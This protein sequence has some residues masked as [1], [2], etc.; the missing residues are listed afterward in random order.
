MQLFKRLQRRL[1]IFQI[2]LLLASCCA[3]AYGSLRTFE[4]DLE[5]D[6]MR[7]SDVIARSLAGQ[8][9]RALE[10]GIAFRHF[11]GVEDLF[12][13]VRASNPEI[14]FIAAIDAGATHAFVAGD[15][16]AAQILGSLAPV[17]A[18]EVKSGQAVTPAALRWNQYLVAPRPIMQAEKPLGW[19]LVAVDS[20]YIQDKISEIFYDILVVL[21]V[22]LL[23]TFELLLLIMSTSSTPMLALQAVFAQVGAKDDADQAGTQHWPSP[24]QQLAL[25]MRT[26][27]RRLEARHR[28]LTLPAQAASALTAP[29]DLLRAA[30][31]AIE[32]L[33][34]KHTTMAMMAGQDALVRVRLPLFVFFLAEELS[35]SFFPIFVRGL[36]LSFTGL[37]PEIVVSLPM[38]LFMLVVAFTQPLGGPWVERLGARRLMLG[39]ALLGAVGLAL[40]ATADNLTA[41]LAFRLLTAVGYG[42][43]FVAGQGHVVAQTHPGNRAWGLA[44]FVGSVLAASICGPAIGGILADRI[45]YRWTFAVGSSMAL[46]AAFLAWRLLRTASA[47]PAAQRRPLRL[48][49]VGVVLR[50]PRFLALIG[51]GAMPAK[52]ILTGFL[53]YLAPLYLAHLGN[54]Q[55]ATGRI[56]MLYGLMMVLLT[57]IAA[58]TAD[59]VGRP[60][61]FVVL[62]GLLSG[63]GLLGVLWS[64]STGMVL[65]GIVILGLAQAIS[66]TPQLSLVPVACAEE[67]KAMGQVTVIGFFRLFERIGSALGPLFAAF[68]LRTF[69]YVTAIVAIGGGVGL[70]CILLGL[71][72]HFSPGRRDQAAAAPVL[73]AV[74]ASPQMEKA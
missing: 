69:D 28:S 73:S 51:L 32:A 44:M 41:L 35:R 22:S 67:C 3:V 13:S 66:I 47:S 45:G 34:S 65:F 57:P 58:R 40:T 26:I 20:H 8:F 70:A 37:S 12:S 29:T 16:R 49:D 61:L 53:Y 52:I 19:L 11:R 64:A 59:R 50:N 39:G 24:V 55:S 2:F 74:T 9:E 62:G 43:V 71:T 18:G 4:A 15:A 46:L 25:V 31:T 6:M 17:L 48:R 14:G 72:W 63:A 30:D 68:L 38:M 27:V 10:S 36:H 5:P 21:V 7:K 1:F 56:M 54:S 60:L 33:R 42:A 23:L